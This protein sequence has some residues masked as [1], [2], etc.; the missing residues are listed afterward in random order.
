[1]LL[2]IG[3]R[4]GIPIEGLVD[5]Y[6]FWL[7]RRNRP[8]PGNGTALGYGE[9]PSCSKYERRRTYFEDLRESPNIMFVRT[10]PQWAIWT[11]PCGYHWRNCESIRS[12]GMYIVVI[13]NIYHNPLILFKLKNTNIVELYSR[14]VKDDTQ[15]TYY[16]SGIGTYVPDSSSLSSFTQY[17]SHQWD[18]AFAT[19]ISYRS[20]MK[21]V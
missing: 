9:D 2:V 1:M 4:Q 18:K 12:Q 19:Y 20:A 17:L 11:E 7:C 15:L 10:S 6:I 13:C 5:Y 3:G 14:L 21:L 16:N 8:L